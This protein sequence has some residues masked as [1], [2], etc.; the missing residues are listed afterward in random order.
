MTEW[1]SWLQTWANAVP[2]LPSPSTPIFD[3]T[4]PQTKGRPLPL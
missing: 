1:P 2:Q 3:M 4:L